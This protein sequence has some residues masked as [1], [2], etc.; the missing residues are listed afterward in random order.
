MPMIALQT[1]FATTPIVSRS[2]VN[3]TRIALVGNVK[4]IDAFSPVPVNLPMNVTKD[5][6]S[7]HPTKF[8]MKTPNVQPKSVKMGDVGVAALTEI[9]T[10]MS[11]A[12]TQNVTKR[13]VDILGTVVRVMIVF[14]TGVFM[15]AKRIL[16]AVRITIVG[17]ASV[18]KDRE[19]IVR[20]IL[21]VD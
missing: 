17:T 4:K 5:N 15:G 21:S 10:R 16:T 14:K 18:S 12:S 2:Y 7:Y 3:V 9:V 19:R 8:V 6:V 11:F 13:D 20:S 1:T